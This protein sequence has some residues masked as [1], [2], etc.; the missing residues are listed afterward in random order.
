MLY[1]SLPVLSQMFLK[2]HK[3]G[4]QTTSGPIGHHLVASILEFDIGGVGGSVCP[5]FT[6]TCW[7]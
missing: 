1:P 5:S 3:T 4:L 2:P 6:Q 7:S